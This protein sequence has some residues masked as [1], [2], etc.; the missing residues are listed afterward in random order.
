MTTR[1]G[2]RLVSSGLWWALGH[3]WTANPIAARWFD[4]ALG[5]QLAA[6]REIPDPVTAYTVEP[7]PISA[8]MES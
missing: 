4:S 8:A 6:L 1:Y 5:A 3:H 2:I 7:I